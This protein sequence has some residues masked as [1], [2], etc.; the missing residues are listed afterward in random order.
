MQIGYN[1]FTAYIFIWFFAL[2]LSRLST[3][4]LKRAS[5]T[6][7]YWLS[8]IVDRVTLTVKLTPPEAQRRLAATINP[9]IRENSA[10]YAEQWVTTEAFEIDRFARSRFLYTHGEIWS[11]PEGSLITVTWKIPGLS[12]SL[13]A[14]VAINP[15]AISSPTY[16]ALSLGLSLLVGIGYYY[17]CLAEARRAK[18]F[19]TNLL[20]ATGS[21][22]ALLTKPDIR[23]Q[24]PILYDDHGDHVEL[25]KSKDG[26]I[27]TYSSRLSGFISFLVFI[28]IGVDGVIFF[29][30]GQVLTD[31]G[32]QWILLIILLAPFCGSLVLLYYAIA[33]WLNRT[34]VT[35]T[36]QTLSVRYQPLPT[37]GNITLPTAELRQLYPKR[38]IVLFNRGGG[39][40]VVTY[41]LRAILKNN[42][43]LTLFEFN[44]PEQVLSTKQQIEA[45]LRLN[46]YVLE[47]SPQ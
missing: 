13:L 46:N 11:H 36:R 39:E 44:S 8:I 45:W 25:E 16:L 4:L 27:F 21:D 2:Y 38:V 28:V 29:I 17:L 32:H 37:Y 43:H 41:E 1:W 18:T 10:P 35:L 24:E 42:K 5:S 22:E 20:N 33:S 47:A 31:G 23:D 26:L 34:V 15:L 19:L 7:K 6:S 12:L 30:A 9:F 40:S 14:F 3:L